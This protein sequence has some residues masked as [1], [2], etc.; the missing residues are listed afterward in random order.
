MEE[1]PEVLNLPLDLK[2]QRDM[3]AKI[4]L[5]FA[6]AE[7]RRTGGKNELRSVAKMPI[8]L[9]DDLM[10]HYERLYSVDMIVVGL[11]IGFIIWLFC[12]ADGP[13]CGC[14]QRT[15]HTANYLKKLKQHE[16][17]LIIADHPSDDIF[18][19][20]VALLVFPSHDSLVI[21]G[22][23][24]RSWSDIFRRHHIE[25]G[26]NDRIM[27]RFDDHCGPV[28]LWS[29]H[30]VLRFKEKVLCQQHPDCNP[31]IPVDLKAVLDRFI[32]CLLA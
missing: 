26:T 29:N 14:R 22:L 18:G 32:K 3:N 19:S 28:E 2:K 15:N 6:G 16:T 4:Y 7:G 20:S 21:G 1:C 9:F 25:I 12:Q 24:E 17:S 13:S 5:F 31:D 27:V 23:C 30:L 8:A 10:V 11:F